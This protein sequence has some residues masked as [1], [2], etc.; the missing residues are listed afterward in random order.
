MMDINI[1]V[2]S[3]GILKVMFN[4]FGCNRTMCGEKG[5]SPSGPSFAY[6]LPFWIIIIVMIANR[7][8]KQ[9]NMDIGVGGMSCNCNDQI[10]IMMI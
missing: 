9:T 4:P 5:V 8:I 3:E 1:F 2:C 6:S 10:I 7:L